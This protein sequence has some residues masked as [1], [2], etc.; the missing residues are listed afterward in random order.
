MK[1][2]NVSSFYDLL[3]EDYD[4]MTSFDERLAKEELIFKPIVDKYKIK[5]ALD[6]GCGTGFHSIVLS[7]LG[8]NVTAVDISS[9][10]IQKLRD[11]AK[12]D[13]LN[14][15]AIKCDF[16]KLPIN[17]KYDAIF[18]MGNTLAH[19]KTKRE[20]SIILSNFY[21]VL[22]RNG[23]LFIQILNYDKI[24]ASG[25]IIQ[26]IKEANGKIF[27]RFY[28]YKEKLIDFNILT[29]ERNE[30]VLRHKLQTTKL[31][32][33]KRKEVVDL[34]KKIGFRKIKTYGS[35]SLEKFKI[36]ESRDLVIA[37]IK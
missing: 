24:I 18:C 16:T 11:R 15:S 29:I 21:K 28:G 5:S 9:K 8:V 23:L 32:L 34:S 7:K 30:G 13:N 2:Q 19:T 31:R 36:N 12:R 22:N 33:L 3:S 20:L 35:N 25:E 1:A 10:M 6:A 4:L 27:V 37:A 14:I 26:S 17:K